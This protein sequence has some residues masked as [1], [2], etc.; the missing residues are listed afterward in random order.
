MEPSC[1]L[2]TRAEAI[3]FLGVEPAVFDRLVA[4]RLLRGQGE[5]A[6]YAIRDL[7]N[8]RVLLLRST[9]RRPPRG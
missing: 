6:G 2:L 9:R 8:L 1:D 5:P 4:T 3:Q 7:A